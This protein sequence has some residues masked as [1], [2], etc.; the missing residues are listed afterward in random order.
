MYLKMTNNDSRFYSPSKIATGHSLLL[1]AKIK[2][3]QT[4]KI[5]HRLES[6]KREDAL[7]DLDIV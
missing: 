5:S 3:N 4:E 6:L 1:N 7:L 2:V